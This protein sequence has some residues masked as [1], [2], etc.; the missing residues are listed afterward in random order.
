MTMPAAVAAAADRVDDDDDDA[1]VDVAVGQ[2]RSDQI[3][4]DR[5]SAAV[6]VAFDK[7]ASSSSIE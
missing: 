6:A 2:N 5:I 1:G 7:Q 3:G 4:S